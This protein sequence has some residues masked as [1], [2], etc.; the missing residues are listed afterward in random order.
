[1]TT[2]YKDI[3]LRYVEYSDQLNQLFNNK[4]Y[5]SFNDCWSISTKYDELDITRSSG[6]KLIFNYV[7]KLQVRKAIKIYQSTNNI[8]DKLK[9]REKYN[10]DFIE[11][12]QQKDYE[13][14][15]KKLDEQQ[16]EAVVACE[17]ASL[18]LAPAGSGKTISLL[19]KIE[20]LVNG[21]NIPANKI[22]AISFT[23]KTVRELK[24]RIGINGVNINT[25]HSLGNKILK[26]QLV[27]KKRI[28]QEKQIYKFIKDELNNLITENQQFS[29]SFNDY[30]LFYY[31]TPIDLTQLKTLKDTVEFN[32]SFLRQTLQSISLN[33]KEYST[34]SPTL[35]GEFV[36]SKEE[37]IIANWLFI[38][39]VPYVY[40]KQ[41]EF[42]DT[43][44]KPDFTL[45]MFNEPL[46]LEH[47]ALQE[48]G[49]S[50]FN[51]YVS[52]VA[53]KRKLHKE[54][55]TKLLESYTY[56]WKNGTLLNHIENEIKSTGIKIT[57]LA[58]N[59]ITKI[60]GDSSQ[61]S[62]DIKSFYEVLV[63]FLMLQKN[64]MLSLTD[65][66]KKI[67]NIDNEY[68]KRRAKLFFE[69]YKPIYLK[70]EQY[71][72]DKKMIDFA[73]M[74][75]SSINIVEKSSDGD[76]PFEYILID[77][78]QDLSYNRYKLVKA[79]LSK[80]PNSKLFAV[81]DDWQ[82]IFRFA[83]GDLSLIQD[84][85]DTF[86]LNTKRSFIAMTHRFGNP[87]LGLSSVFVQKNPYQSQKEV[88][89]FDTNKTPILK[90]F[91]NRRYAENNNQA[92]SEESKTVNSIL[93]ELQNKYGEDLS[94]KNIQII[95]RYNS[96]IDSILGNPKKAIA[97]HNNFRV[98]KSDTDSEEDEKEIFLEWKSG[99]SM[100]PVK[101]AFCSMHKAKGITRDI[102]IILNMNSGSNGMPS[103]R[104]SDP[105]IE[106]L[107]SHSD[108][109]PF[110]E[111][112]RLFYVA[113]TRAKE[114]TYVVADKTR[115]SQ[116]LFEIFDDVFGED[117][118]CPNCQVGEIVE[119][120]GQ[121]GKFY[122]CSNFRFGC[123]Y[124]KSS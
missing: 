89:G 110:A 39:Q 124:T 33:K 24:D 10:L 117:K 63:T 5:V 2:P 87:Q 22:L 9:N 75:N 76:Y 109:Y 122:S 104:S 91:F 18:V 15:N 106:L 50:H 79:L 58:E 88:F 48:D 16:I 95:S 52:G 38:N 29:K 92:I 93:D 56:Q 116:F 108:Q 118:T 3:V 112:R 114:A 96:D 13:S 35:K 55:G 20:Y 65:I 73:D 115:P 102:V 19:A 4:R 57:R 47:F 82:S 107:L 1:M 85:E 119:K 34:L 54:N 101:L 74:I 81:G 123:D 94:S 78:V 28:I 97:P 72:K 21:L 36:K 120:N 7:S 31:S 11:Q 98:I 23:R 67:T 80:N 37:Q 59:E 99:L 64:G 6:L 41:Y 62:S 66:N 113:I 30:L 111:E 27:E 86:E 77:E 105:M 8:L 83:G 100:K 32:K 51:N 90:R 17:D 14:D 70:Y 45:T 69:I 26:D 103:L 46:Y 42:I 40:E 121:Y 43:K 60:M 49:S 84:F 44:Y 12:E 25:F 53:W 61:Y 68:I 71:L